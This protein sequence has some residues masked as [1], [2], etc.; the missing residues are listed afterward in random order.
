[1]ERDLQDYLI[2]KRGLSERTAYNHA[3]RYRRVISFF[4]K[5]HLPLNNR[6]AEYYLSILRKKGYEPATL[7]MYID[8][9]VLLDK[10][11]ESRDKPINISSGFKRFHVNKRPIDILTSQ[12]VEK[13][14]STPMRFYQPN[15]MW[16]EQDRHYLA[17]TSFLGYTG[18]RFGEAQELR[19]KNLDTSTGKVLIPTSKNGSYRFVYIPPLIIERIKPCLKHKNPDD[20]VFTTTRGHKIYDSNFIDNLKKR[21]L[22]CGIKK[23]I[24][25]HLLRHSFCTQLLTDGVPIEQVAT[26]MGHA[27][28]ETTFTTYTHLADNTVRRAMYRHVLFKRAA[29]P[30]EIIQ[31]IVATFK[32]Y[33]L[34]E[35]KRFIYKLR[36]SGKSFSL[37]ISCK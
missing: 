29:E 37:Q 10:Y 24:Y 1:M 34:D 13:V 16:Q 7:N 36:E 12:E 27:S 11:Y 2:I 8:L 22:Q 6:S 15:R 31:H 9:F 4:K 21:A 33:K 19:V 3:L 30:S 35:D 20:L 26:I 32:G 23:R 18:C 14:C 5:H 28:T 17:L 25:P